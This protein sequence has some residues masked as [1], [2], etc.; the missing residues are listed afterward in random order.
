MFGLISKNTNHRLK[1]IALIEVLK[2]SIVESVSE[3][4]LNA[5]DYVVDK[6]CI[7]LLDDRLNLLSDG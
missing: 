3:T 6:G 4:L 7:F 1:I 5:G 2:D